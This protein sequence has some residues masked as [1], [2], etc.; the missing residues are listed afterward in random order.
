MYILV[1]GP[2]LALCVWT[3]WLPTF[4]E[5]QRQLHRCAINRDT[6]CGDRGRIPCGF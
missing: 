2:F 4:T 5:W 1:K 6:R 3:A